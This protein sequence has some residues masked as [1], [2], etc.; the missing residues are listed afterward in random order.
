[1][2]LVPEVVKVR[3]TLMF[4]FMVIVKVIVTHVVIGIVAVIVI[5]IVIVILCVSATLTVI[6]DVCVVQRSLGYDD[7]TVSQLARQTVQCVRLTSIW[8]CKICGWTWKLPLPPRGT[9]LTQKAGTV[10]HAAGGG[11]EL[12]ARAAKL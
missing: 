1:M 7:S 3:V 10:G 4:M 8:T 9:G 2:V 6:V 12:C 11:V 5:K